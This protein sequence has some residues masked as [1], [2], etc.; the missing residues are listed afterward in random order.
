ML[1]RVK[2]TI[3]V[4]DL[5]IVLAILL[6]VIVL[7]NVFPVLL[8][9]A[10]NTLPTASFTYSP[11]YPQP[12]VPV[13]FNAS[14]SYSPNGTIVLYQWNFGDGH[15]ANVSFPV[16]NYTY[17][18]DGNYQVTLY[19]VDNNGGIGVTWQTLI[20][21]FN[22]WFRV[23][24]DQGNPIANVTVTVYESD[25]ATSTNWQ[26][27]PT[28]PS[29]VEILYDY[30]T[31]P[32]L[33]NSQNKYRNPGI[34][35]S[36]LYDDVSNIGFEIHPPQ[37]YV[38]FKFQW[39]S[40]V[41]YW[42]NATSQVL[43]Y[44]NGN[45]ETNY[46][47]P[48]HQA[49]F[50]SAA[51]T[52][53][54]LAANGP[55]CGVAPVPKRPVLHCGPHRSALTVSISPTSATVDVG[56]SQTFTSTAL[57][58]SP[59]YTYQW[60]LNNIA[61]SG[62]KNP[63]WTFTPTSSGSYTVYLNVTDSTCKK[64]KSNIASV[65]VNPALSVSIS[66]TSVVIDVGQ[67][68][69]FTSTVSGGTSPYS[70]QWY[71]NNAPV[72]G[73]TS[74]SW[75]FTP[76]SSGSYTVYV[77]ATD[78]VGARAKSNIAAVTVNAVLSVTISPSSV[79]LD[80]GQS[81]LFT[82]T[83]SGG[84]SP[85]TYQWYLDG[86]AVSGA[87]SA[88]WTYTPSASGSHTV[89]VKVTDSVSAVATSNTATVTVNGALS[90]T[91]SPT[92]V[93]MDVG[94]SRTFTSTVSGGTGPFSYQ[95]YLDGSVVS[96][97]TSSTW[98]YTPSAAGSHTV[99]VKVTDSA[100]TPVTAQSNTAGIV[101]NAALSVTIAPGSATLDVGQSQTFTS[102]VT[103]GTSPFSYQWYLDG[104]VVSGATSASWT[105]TASASGSHTVYVKVTDSATT[106]VC[107]TSNTASVAVNAALSV[108]ITPTSVTLDVGQ[109][110][111]F[112]STVSGGTGPFSYQWYLNGAPV[113]GATSAMWTYAPPYAGSYAVY[114]VV[115]DS[116]STPKIA[117]SGTAHVTVDSQLAV[118]ISP[119]N[120]AIYLS[121]SQTFTSLVSNGT[122]PYTYQWYQNN[123][124]VS[125]A[126][127]SS[128]TF[129]PAYTGVYIVYSKVT[130]GVSEVAQ[131]SNAKL[132]VNP[133]PSMGV[134]ISPSSTV[135][136]IGQSVP[137]TSN[138]T[139]GIS[140]FTYQWYLNGNAVSG[141][142][143]ST[144]TFTPNST[145][146]YQVYLNVTDSLSVQAK[147]NTAFV[148]VNSLPSVSINPSSVTLDVG[149]SQTF[150]S[151]VT[152]GTS[153]FSYQW[154]LDGSVV[155]G[156]TS[157]SWTYTASAS[158]SHTVYVKVTDSASTPVTA[159]SNTASVAVNAALSVSITPTSVT[160]DV[161][162]SQTFTSTVT[163]GT[164]PFSYQWYLDGSVVSGATSASWTYTAS[165]SGSHTV[166][167]KVTDSATTP[168]CATSNTA[169][170]AVNA[171]LSVAILPGSVTL[172][173]GQSQ[174]FTSTVTGGTG[175][176]S[177]QWYLD[178]SA[179]FGATSS[180]WT[181]TPAV[182][183]FSHCL[184]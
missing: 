123:T 156:A 146:N 52:Y 13:T 144:W 158:G 94:Q 155:S 6:S 39:G 51:S 46:Y 17:S 118:S 110:Q 147:S 5:R 48:A 84:T 59:P 122:L 138:L 107:A 171:A 56:Q 104:S 81:K 161:G 163:G 1:I 134:T 12:N 9:K 7:F 60:Y 124:L 128:W 68:K 27:A 139:G 91:I 182:C 61:V 49:V 112:T 159:Q 105:Y 22:A 24:D 103:G 145:G 97:A 37:T 21:N 28:G 16:I 75:T 35:A 179:V 47:S 83:V 157:A 141:A 126:T 165:A 86:S 80:A 142:T 168:V 117:Q 125:G 44:E 96:G 133:K 170:V 89:F 40:N 3:A 31:Q 154:Y 50:N 45:I 153:P 173:V 66:P 29:G 174:T 121:Q 30:E 26:V 88:T 92:S 72:S 69:L 169:S 131:S 38:F 53:V 102:T 178:G 109:S 76:I 90:V 99:Y 54:I 78:N 55:S 143:S 129:T 130:D 164:S 176:F 18:D 23:V 114:V 160:L 149:Q 71:L 15:T 82:S 58:G 2:E 152:G 151:T 132:T 85:Y 119:S 181:Y 172:D 106:P 98:T 93:V 135:I 36:I 162:Q 175:P 150:T 70:Y 41:F 127:S 11:G 180:T 100:S 148:T 20:V 111:L 62:A 32:N 64:A 34:T 10:D 166:Y 77:N 137:F 167:V 108:S 14:Q 43:S 4:R 25:S 116:A 42:P 184:C 65:T 113:S 87:T 120:A 8:V 177:Y 183:W 140:P 74:S 101:V 67:S 19:V 33:A 115:T 79:T 57:G 95:W 136:D 73:A 63:T